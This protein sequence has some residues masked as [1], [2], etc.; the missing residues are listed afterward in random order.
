MMRRLPNF[1]VKELEVLVLDEADRLLELGFEN[2]LSQILSRLPKQRRTGLFSATMTDEVQE[3]ARAGLR[4]PVRVCVRDTS[5]KAKAQSTPLGLQNYYQICDAEEKF[6]VLV[7]LLSHKANAHAKMIVYFLTCASTEFWHALLKRLPQ[8]EQRKFFALHGKMEQKKRTR[9][10][11]GFVDSEGGILICTDVAARGLDIPE[12]DWIVQYDPPQNPEQFVHRVGRTARLGRQG[13]AIVLLQ[14]SEDAYIEFLRIRKCPLTETSPRI[15]PLDVATLAKTLVREDRELIEKSSRAFVSYVRGYK[16]HQCNYIFRFEEL[17]LA[18]AARS[19]HLAMLPK[20]A[21]LR[22]RK[23]DFTSE[24]VDLDAIPFKDKKRQ[25]Q[26]ERALQEKAARA[27]TEESSVVDGAAAAESAGAKYT[28]GAFGKKRKAE[29]EAEEAAPSRVEDDGDDFDDMMKEAGL[30]K[31]LRRGE[32]TEAEYD[33]MCG[34]LSGSDDD[35]SGAPKLGKREKHAK[36]KAAKA[37][38]A[39]ERHK[40]RKG[41]PGG[42]GGKGGDGHKS[43]K[44]AGKLPRRMG[45]MIAKK[46][47]GKGKG[48]GGKGGAKAGR[49]NGG[50]GSAR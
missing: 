13:K 14:P 27:A 43:V 48:K 50:K 49:R 44:A 41:Q 29:A 5:K 15:G 40:K 36:L 47:R 30:L 22:G 16:E 18:A 33:R 28:H 31:K 39:D 9:Q 42:K 6:G 23:I 25:K 21:E 8:L 38:L 45:G 32:I 46:K 17:D 35:G 19:F 37:S 20:M 2:T 10:Y 12:V 24:R 26:R 7:A 11:K 34:Y 4:N 3:L 1:S